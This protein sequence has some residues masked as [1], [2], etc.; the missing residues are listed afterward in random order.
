MPVISSLTSNQI[1]LIIS[2]ICFFIS[3]IITSCNL[4]SQVPANA[5][6]DCKDIAI[7]LPATGLEAP[8]WEESDRVFLERAIIENIP[9]A[10]IRHF[11]ANSDPQLQE[12]QADLAL[13]KG[14]CILIVAPVDTN[15]ASKVV[16]NAEAK[17]VPVIA[18]DRFIDDEGLDF[19]VSFSSK[20]VGQFQAEYL[21]RQLELGESGLYKLKK[22]ANLVMI[23]G[24]VKDGNTQRIEEGWFETLQPLFDSKN[25]NLV[26]P[27]E[28]GDPDYFM[29]GWSGEKAAETVESLLDE[30][31]NNIPIILVAN[32][33]MAEEIIGILQQ[34]Q[35]QGQ[36]LVTGQDGSLNSA[37]Y[38]VEGLQGITLYKPIDD[39]LSKKTIDVINA[40]RDG[41]DLG[42]LANNVE[43]TTQNS[44]EIPAYL[45]TP[46]RV[47][48]ENIEDTLMQKYGKDKVCD[49]VRKD[50]DP[51]Q[52]CQ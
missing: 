45:F 16:Q 22:G 14:S 49:N 21:L 31:Q 29:E 37:I 41:D 25:L 50:K 28:K 9:D 33:S 26:F 46:I 24:D 19:Y 30:Y 8:R 27:K 52:L 17:G 40:L 18:Y 6:Q 39:N 15:E 38:I 44:K 20:Q 23:N 3:A 47:T 35:K 11:N 5:S 34:K 43:I 48:A 32:D 51:Y 12:Q 2:F 36:V 4:I 42:V 13:A 7:L 10:T 1:K